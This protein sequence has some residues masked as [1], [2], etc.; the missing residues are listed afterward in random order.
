[1]SYRANLARLKR[2]ERQ[3]QLARATVPD[4]SC[5]EFVIAPELAR[6]IIDAHTRLHELLSSQHAYS[7]LGRFGGPEKPDPAAEEEA[8]ARLA[9]LLLDVRCPADYWAKQAD[10][11]RRLWEDDIDHS[12]DELDP[13]RARLIVFEGS[14]VGAV[15]RR[16]MELSYRPRT[17]AQQAELVELTRSY[18]GMPL[19]HHSRWYEEIR[20]MEEIV[21]KASGGSDGLSTRYEFEETL[22]KRVQRYR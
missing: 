22:W 18:P 11:D 9:E 21:R 16:M 6:A 1:M 15:W 8:A 10:T 7:V 20:N 3:M 17:P 19:E 4:L 13:V 12:A 2:L 5:S 14:S